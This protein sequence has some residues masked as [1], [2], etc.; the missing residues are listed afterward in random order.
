MARFESLTSFDANGPQKIRIVISNVFHISHRFHSKQADEILL[1]V[2]GPNII[3]GAL[4]HWL[5]LISPNTGG[6]YAER[7]HCFEFDY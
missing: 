5:S 3:I 2:N 7:I 4:I 6:N 1:F